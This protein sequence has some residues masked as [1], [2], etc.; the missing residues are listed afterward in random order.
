MHKVDKVRRVE[1]ESS[2]W[3]GICTC[4]WETPAAGRTMVLAILEQ[5]IGGAAN[6]V[7]VDPQA[8]ARLKEINVKMTQAQGT[9]EVTVALLMREFIY[10][11]RKALDL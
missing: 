3:R 6:V 7:Q 5:H 1:V 2:W 8:L 10:E 9:D 11:T 4:G